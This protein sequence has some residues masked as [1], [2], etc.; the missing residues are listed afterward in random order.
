MVLGAWWWA[1]LAVWTW[2]VLFAASGPRSL[3][4]FAGGGLWSAGLALLTE[5]LIRERFGFFDAAGF[6]LPLAGADALLFAGPRF[7]EGV[8]FMQ[9]MRPA[10]QRLRAAGWAAAV[11]LSETGMAVTGHAHLSPAA[12]AAT[13][14][15]HALRFFALLASS[16]RGRTPRP[17]SG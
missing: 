10:G 13:L 2:L 3:R 6:L 9:T 17:T 12:F 8:L 16:W 11:T 7:V 14:A 4:A 15:G 1:A 5:S